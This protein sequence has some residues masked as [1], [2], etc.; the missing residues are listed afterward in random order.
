MRLPL[1]P[2]GAGHFV[3]SDGLQYCL[4]EKVPGLRH[5]NPRKAVTVIPIRLVQAAALSEYALVILDRHANNILFSACQSRTVDFMEPR[6]A[7]AEPLLA[8]TDDLA[9]LS[10]PNLHKVAK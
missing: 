10:A 2:G 3:G 9:R 4:T 1:G 6:L 5:H 8:P 7:F